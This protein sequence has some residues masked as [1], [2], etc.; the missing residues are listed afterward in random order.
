VPEETE[1]L[2]RRIVAA[3]EVASPSP[4]EVTP[5]PSNLALMDDFAPFH[6]LGAVL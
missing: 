4:R 3:N 2:E 5:F 1:N 6:S